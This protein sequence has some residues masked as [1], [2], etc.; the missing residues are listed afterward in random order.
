MF[1]FEEESY[2]D[3]LNQSVFDCCVLGRVYALWIQMCLQGQ[4][5]KRLKHWILVKDVVSSRCR[6]QCDK[7]ATKNDTRELI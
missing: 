2:C 4:V 7:A 1:Q 5:Q 6:H 3:L